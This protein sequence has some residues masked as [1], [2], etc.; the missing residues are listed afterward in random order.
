MDNGIHFLTKL[1]MRNTVR[2][3][4]HEMPCVSNEVTWLE[5]G[6]ADERVAHQSGE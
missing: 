3:I 5:P 4:S 6:P 1:H 2:P